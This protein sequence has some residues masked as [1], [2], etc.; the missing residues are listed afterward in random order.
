MKVIVLAADGPDFSSGHDLRAGFELPGD[1][2]ATMEGHANCL[3]RYG[4]LMDPSGADVV[5]SALR[6]AR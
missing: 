3:A 2:V 5:R 1:P 4:Q 6:A